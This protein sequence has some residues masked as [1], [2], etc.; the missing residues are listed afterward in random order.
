[1]I[2]EY[3]DIA[4]AKSTFAAALNRAKVDENGHFRFQRFSEPSQG[5]KENKIQGLSHEHV[6]ETPSSSILYSSYTVENTQPLKRGRPSTKPWFKRATVEGTPVS[7]SLSR[8][9][10]IEIMRGSHH[11]EVIGLPLNVMITLKPGRVDQIEPQN[12]FAFW[13]EELNYLS[14]VC[15]RHSAKPAFVWVREGRKD[16][17][18]EHMHVLAH[19]TPRVRRALAKGLAARHPEATEVDIRSAT[20]AGSPSDNGKHFSAAGYLVKEMSPQAA[21]ATNTER[22]KGSPI[23]GKR[24]G[25]TRNVSNKAVERFRKTLQ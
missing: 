14:Q 19:A 25:T 6:G 4:P 9:E 23:A 22:R 20:S 10:V 15:R 18:G 21:F 2:S 7:R 3:Y 12:R 16:G 13:Q 24:C 11:A 8:D 5:K 17:T 1:M